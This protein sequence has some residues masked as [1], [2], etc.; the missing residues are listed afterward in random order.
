MTAFGY[1]ITGISDI[2]A[3]G[4]VGNVIAEKP[5]RQLAGPSIVRIYLTRESVDVEA[6][7]TIGGT[8][9]FPSGPVNV[10]A[11]VGTLPSTQDDE[12]I[13]VVAQAGDSIIIAGTNANAAKQELRAL[14]KVTLVDD[15]ILLHAAA[16]RKG[17]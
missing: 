2:D 1:S 16:I 10:V 13:T 8:N 14:V 5:G 12:V 9:V 6:Q 11:A 17:S 4:S 3:T 15:A 7:V